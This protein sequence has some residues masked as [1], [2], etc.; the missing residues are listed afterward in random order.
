M[1]VAA[2]AAVGGVDFGTGVDLGS[3]SRTPD[4]D[5]WL[6]CVAL[7]LPSVL[8]DERRQAKEER[9]EARASE[10]SWA[11]LEWSWDL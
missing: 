10:V 2:S 6:F 8:W 11:T 5:L 3:W 9:E 1:T 4:P 7:A